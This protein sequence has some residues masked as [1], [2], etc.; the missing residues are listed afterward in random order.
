M[1][2][3]LQAQELHYLT[4]SQRQYSHEQESMQNPNHHHQQHQITTSQTLESIDPSASGK[5]AEKLLK[6]C[7][8]AISEKDSGKIHHFL[9]MLNELASPYGDCDQKLAYYFLQAFFCKA[10]ES[11]ERCYK[12]L[13]SVAEKSHSFESARKVILKFQEVSP[14]TTFGHVASNGA[15]L[16]AMDGEAKLHI[17]DISSTYC[18]QWP[19]LLEALATRNDDTPHLRL[20]V[21]VTAGTGGSVMKEIGQRMEKFARLMGVPF[22]FNVVSGFSRLG[23]LKEEDFGVRD[24][25]AVA[26]NCIGALRKVS[27]I[28]RS[29]FI[30]M[31]HRLRPKVVTVVEEEAD[32]TSNLDEFIA[33]SEECLRFYSI[34]FEMLEESFVPTSNERLMLERESSRSIL[35]VLACEGEGGGECERREKGSQWC[36]RLTGDFSPMSFNDDGVDDVKALLRRYRAGW[37]LLPAQGTDASGLYLTWKDEPVVWASAWKPS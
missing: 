14:W 27:V 19:T 29:S 3:T 31:L 30:R 23:E 15:I 32:F 21:V 25:E 18:T 24:D 22:E 16:E 17:I 33:C 6:E 28:E 5:W 2:I 26:V 13:I 36:E 35:S 8:K 10:T 37:A 4:L 34:F 12:T 9:W 7:A 1:D 20:T 11:G